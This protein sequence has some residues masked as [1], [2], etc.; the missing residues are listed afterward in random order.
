MTLLTDRYG[1]ILSIGVT[2]IIKVR[3]QSL[4]T[5]TY[6]LTAIDITFI[7]NIIFGAELEL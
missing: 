4:F 7:D 5:E 3:F 1:I 2:K 6:N